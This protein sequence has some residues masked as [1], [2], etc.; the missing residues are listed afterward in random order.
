MEVRIENQVI[1]F[2]IPSR[3]HQISNPAP[4]SLHDLNDS[5]DSGSLYE[6]DSLI[7]QIDSDTSV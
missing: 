4:S 7:G 3:N 6:S 1:P 5:Q 2:K